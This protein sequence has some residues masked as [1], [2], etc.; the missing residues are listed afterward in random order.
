MSFAICLVAW[1]PVEGHE[2]SREMATV[3]DLYSAN[4]G[5]SAQPSWGCTPFGEGDQQ[6]DS[7]NSKGW[8]T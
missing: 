8:V 7:P 3:G 2:D 1:Y 4:G 6:G 5:W